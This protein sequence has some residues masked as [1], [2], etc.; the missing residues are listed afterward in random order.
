MTSSSTPH[1]D[2]I[3]AAFPWR[4]FLLTCVLTGLWIN[5]S[6]VARYFLV[7]LPMLRDAFPQLDNVAPISW[8][9]AAIW[10]LW[11][12]VLVLSATGFIWIYLDRFGT[13]HAN[14]LK[15]AVLFWAAAFCLL[16][17]GVNNMGLAT[18]GIAAAALPLALLEMYLTSLIVLW[19]R[20][21]F[22]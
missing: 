14:A 19:G 18:P 9:V 16:W 13:S 22:Q 6:E 3:H 4:A 20:R 2:M 10:A 11:D 21:R 8:P 1:T 15:A 12:T 17:V 5:V 7:V